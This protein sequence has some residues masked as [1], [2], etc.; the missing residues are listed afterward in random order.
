MLEGQ[1]KNLK[2]E[3]ANEK[4]RREAMEKAAHR[5]ERDQKLIEE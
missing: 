3:V 2:E 5:A 1:L 4:F